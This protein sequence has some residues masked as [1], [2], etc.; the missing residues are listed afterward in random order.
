M[1][2]IGFVE[3]QECSGH[4]LILDVLEANRHEDDSK[5][6]QLQK[7]WSVVSVAVM[8]FCNLNFWNSRAHHELRGV[9]FFI[10]AIT[11]SMVSNATQ[12]LRWSPCPIIQVL[13]GVLKKECPPRLRAEEKER[14]QY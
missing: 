13:H 12:K 10:A 2:V 5:N 14:Q 1:L 7:S 11:V 4:F 9:H 6:R 3:F 8:T